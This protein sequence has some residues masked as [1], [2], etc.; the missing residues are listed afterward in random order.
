[1]ICWCSRG[2]VHVVVQLHGDETDVDILNEMRD[3]L[4]L[5]APHRGGC[6]GGLRQED[7]V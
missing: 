6:Q 3:Y 7:V 4:I 1:M 2:I 5:D